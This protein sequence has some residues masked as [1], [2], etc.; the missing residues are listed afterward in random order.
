M[1]VIGVLKGT[2]EGRSILLNGHTDT[3]GINGMDI[4]PLNPI[5][6]DGKVYE[7]GSLDMKSG[8]AAMIIAV[9]SIINSGLKAKGDV[10]SRRQAIGQFAL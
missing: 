6:E 2:G 8:L 5:C 9:R 7:R 10:I 4:E 1:N 3:V